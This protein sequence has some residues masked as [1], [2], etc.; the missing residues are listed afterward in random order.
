MTIHVPRWVIA[1]LGV[2]LV[3]VAAFLIGRSSGDDGS[4]ESA[5]RA[6]AE[7]ATQ[8]APEDPALSCDKA[9]AAKLVN[10]RLVAD[11]VGLGG[12]RPEEKVSDLY[13]ETLIGCQDLDG[14]EL[15][16]L[17]MSLG[18][19][20][21]TSPTPWA[22]FSQ[23]NGRWHAQFV[24][25]Q[26]ATLLKLTDE[27]VRETSAAFTPGEP[28]CC[29]SGRRTGLVSWDGERY[30]YAPRRAIAHPTLEIRKETAVELGGFDLQN[31]ALDGAIDAFGTPSAYAPEAELCTA[32]WTDLGLIINFVH[33][34]GSDPCGPAGRVGS[35]VIAGPEAEQ[36]GWSV[37]GSGVMVG[38]TQE[39]LRATYPS[40]APAVFGAETAQGEEGRSWILVARPSGPGAGD[41]AITLSARL[42]FGEAVAFDIGVG[43]GGE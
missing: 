37:S 6:E 29:P 38:S 19:C 5:A 15:E 33:L 41:R 39:E 13:T 9:T 1:I 10:S 4:G 2:G 12:V 24:R 16:E 26:S 8:A 32:R 14:D 40:M 25:A 42:N 34:G 3:A 36:A 30:V 20:T 18:C 7:E 31:R 22:I 35:I 23:S 28:L 21:G 43:A 27:G 11:A 17:V